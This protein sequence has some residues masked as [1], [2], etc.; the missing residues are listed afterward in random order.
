MAATDLAGKV[1][2]RWTV[3][4]RAVG[5]YE[6]P[7]WVCVCEC[8]TERVVRAAGLVSGTSNSCGCLNAENTSRRKRLDYIDLT[9]T[10]F[11][12]LVVV[13]PTRVV[14]DKLKWECICDC[15]NTTI[16][17]TG[18]LNAGTVFSCGCADKGP[19]KPN[20]L[21][22]R[23]GRLVVVEEY[24]RKGGGG[25][26]WR[27][28]CD[29]GKE[30]VMTTGSLVRGLNVSCGCH[31]IEIARQRFIEMSKFQKRENHP[32]WKPDKT[33]EERILGRHYPAYAEWR[34]AVYKRDG[35]TCQCCGS[36]KSIHAHHLFAY[37][38]YREYRTALNNGITLCKECHIDFHSTY[39]KGKNTPD[40]FYEYYNIVVNKNIP[41]TEEL[42]DK[43]ALA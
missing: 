24:R 6:K 41:V 32:Q 1:F 8:G 16:V 36:K 39:G 2:G 27:C 21:G 42:N 35:Y 23:Y 29:C 31:K 28:V 37:S 3:L 43:I 15:G 12:S 34:V 5:D 26:L 7:R 9:G 17:W 22:N 20:I 38:T 19:K 33:E 4:H 13:G 30:P 40:Q 11:G 14:M 10:R 18:H 25:S